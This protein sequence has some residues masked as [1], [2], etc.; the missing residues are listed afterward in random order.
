MKKWKIF[1]DLK[2]KNKKIKK[3]IKFF[4]NIENGV[5][6]KTMKNKKMK[7]IM[8]WENR[9]WCPKKKLWKIKK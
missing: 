6:K 1:G 7:N 9:K 5:V 3:E 4:K 8:W 2:E